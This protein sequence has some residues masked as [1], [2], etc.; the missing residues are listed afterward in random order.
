VNPYK[1]FINTL[2]YWYVAKDL[3]S[4][5]EM[6]KSE[7]NLFLET[8]NEYH[9][10]NAI[11][12]AALIK[13]LDASFEILDYEREFITGYIMK[14]EIWTSYEISIFGNTIEILNSYT[15][16]TIV[17]ELETYMN[18]KKVTQKNFKNII[19]LLLN[20]CIIFIRRGDFTY[21]EKTLNIVKKYLQPFLFFEKTRSLYV[22]G[23]ILMA[24]Q[25]IKRGLELVNDSIYIMS[26]LEP[27]FAEEHEI[28]LKKFN[29]QF[30]VNIE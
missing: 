29:L 1:K 15:I 16:S 12:I 11:I 25:E 3:D 20:A 17:K 9:K 21:A 5:H 18:T 6:R 24:N 28:E 26:K 19:N 27:K 14:C 23:L 10:C 8:K 13:N 4:L 30:G 22:E 7:S 2:S